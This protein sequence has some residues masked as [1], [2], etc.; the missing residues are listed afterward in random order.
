MK[1]PRDLWQE[2]CS[3]K[4]LELAWRKARKHKAKKQYVIDFEK[5]LAENLTLLRTELLLHAYRPLPL[6]TF[7]LRD[8]KTRVISK[9]DF[10]DRVIHH[11]LC[12][13]IEPIFD[14][15]FIYDSY[16]NRKGKG[17]LAAIK[18]F[19]YFKNKASR[20]LTK[21]DKTKGIKG[22][23]LKADVKHYFDT[24]DHEILVRIIQKKINDKRIIWLIKTILSNHKTKTQGK[25][26]PLGNLTSQFFANVY[27]NE[28]DQ[29]IKHELKA[30][31]YINYIRYV[32]DFV[33]LHRSAERLEYCKEQI[34]RF[35][36]DELALQL[37]PDKSKIHPLYTGTDFLGLR[38]Y[39]YHR[40]LKRRNL[41]KFRKKL[42]LMHSEYKVKKV[43]YDAIYDFLEGWTAYS[44]YTNTFKL[45][46]KQI[47][48]AE[49][50]FGGALSNKELNRYFKHVSLVF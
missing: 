6:K 49:N 3:Y 29:Y 42:E 47:A 36:K 14:K 44:K 28:L 33:I 46:R 50:L 48:H 22:F 32:D 4:N 5:N 1:K 34:N 19:E 39:P 26:M 9:S 16:A 7:I 38:I 41:R 21:I 13:I 25:G 23:V 43:K 27:L 12:N 17:T 35:L 37:H 8:P 2:L 31:H 11:A 24:V 10:R 20:N 30:R 40:L 18:R 45:R 15:A